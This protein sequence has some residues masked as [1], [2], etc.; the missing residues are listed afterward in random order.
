MKTELKDDDDSEEYQP[1]RGGAKEIND[2][3]RGKLHQDW[4]WMKL[5]MGPEELLSKNGGK[6]NLKNEICPES[7]SFVMKW[8]LEWKLEKKD[9]HED[10]DDNFFYPLLWI[11]KS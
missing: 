4:G 1:E 2:C 8:A 11:R 9:L 3:K 7:S 5:Q 6:L 10:N